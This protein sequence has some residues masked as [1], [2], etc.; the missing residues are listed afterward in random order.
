VGR[1]VLFR[2]LG[3]LAQGGPTSDVAAGRINRDCLQMGAN[4]SAAFCER[5]DVNGQE[6]PGQAK[7]APWSP[8]S[9]DGHCDRR[10]RWPT[11]FGRGVSL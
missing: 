10:Q 6:M 8:S 5:T 9:T 11:R 3:T 1:W 2:T 4:G 7:D